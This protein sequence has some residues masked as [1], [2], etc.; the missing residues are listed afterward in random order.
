MK[1]IKDRNLV[2]SF[3][4]LYLCNL[5]VT[6]KLLNWLNCLLHSQEALQ[7][8]KASS[9]FAFWHNVID[10]QEA[11][12]FVEGYFYDFMIGSYSSFSS[13]SIF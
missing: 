1:D 10:C 7:E 3:A 12:R 6:E 4:I 5:R 8:T 2:D 9:E 11:I 13:S